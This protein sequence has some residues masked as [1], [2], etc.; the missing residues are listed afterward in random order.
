LHYINS[1]IV[2][3]GKKMKRSSLAILM[4]SIAMAFLSANTFADTVFVYETGVFP[5]STGT[6][7]IPGFGTIDGVQYGEYDL[8]IDWDKGAPNYVP[9]SGFCVENALSTGSATEYDLIPASTFGPSYA[10]AAWVLNQYILGN[11]NARVAQIAI[12][13][14]VWDAG[15]LDPTYNHGSFYASA[16]N[17][18]ATAAYNFLQAGVGTYNG[19]TILHAP[20][21]SQNPTNPQDYII[22]TATPEPGILIL[23]GIALSAV[24]LAARRFRL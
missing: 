10:Q 18:D 6:F 24:G 15:N 22:P 12:W 21:D 7:T 11:V 20:P 19:Y 9:I 8:M 17:A 1:K 5:G 13:E 4:V 16:G 23:L 3:G 2:K 14:L